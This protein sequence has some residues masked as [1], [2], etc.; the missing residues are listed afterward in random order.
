[1]A[2]WGPCMM[3]V[4]MVGGMHGRGHSWWGHVWQG[5][6]WWWGVCMRGDVWQ[7]VSVTGEMAIAMDGTHPTGMHSC[8][9][10]CSRLC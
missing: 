7:G 10:K 2:G 8:F 3:G 9:Y 1:M 4:C 6:A 5:H